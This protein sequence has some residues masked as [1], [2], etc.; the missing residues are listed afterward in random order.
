LEVAAPTINRQLARI[1]VE[2]KWSDNKDIKSSL[3][4][5]LVRNYLIGHRLSHGIYLV[6]WCGAWGETNKKRAE[7]QLLK[8]YLADQVKSVNASEEGKNLKLE[9]VVLDLRWRDDLPEQPAGSV[10]W[11]P[12]DRAG[13]SKPTSRIEP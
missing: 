1:V 6:G 12:P 4:N 10:P 3:E 5:Q 13:N 11:A 9:T 2:I 8:S 7:I